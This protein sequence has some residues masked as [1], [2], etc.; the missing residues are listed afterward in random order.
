M[1][2][3]TCM[4]FVP[5]VSNLDPMMYICK[6][7]HFCW[8]GFWFITHVFFVI[9]SLFR[10]LSVIHNSIAM[11][12]L[13]NVFHGGI[14]TLVF[15]SWGGCDVHCA[16]PPGLVIYVFSFKLCLKTVDVD[17]VFKNQQLQNF[18]GRCWNFFA[19]KPSSPENGLRSQS[20]YHE[21][22]AKL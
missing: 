3:C 8:R 15:S 1:S 5:K 11:I 22:L 19:R 12:S 21:P 20:Y 9:I 6:L 14:R 2:I 4:Y 16:A 17:Q 7:F 13:K 18:D 10:I